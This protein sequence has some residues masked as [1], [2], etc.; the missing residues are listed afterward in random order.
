M[1]NYDVWR[2]RVLRSWLVIFLP[3]SALCGLQSW[4]A[5][6]GVQYWNTQ[7]TEWSMKALE[8]AKTGKFDQVDATAKMIESFGFLHQAQERL[9]WYSIATGCLLAFPFL[10]WGIAWIMRWIMWPRENKF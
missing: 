10:V 6:K 9:Q 4:D 7:S 1:T 3:L 8:Q 2:K 5:Y